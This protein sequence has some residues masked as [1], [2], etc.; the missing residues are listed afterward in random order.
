MN[1]I[2]PTNLSC[3]KLMWSCCSLNI[4]LNNMESSLC[5]K[6]SHHLKKF[7]G[8]NSWALVQ[9]NGPASQKW[10]ER[11]SGEKNVVHSHM[12]NIAISPQ[13]SSEAAQKEVHSLC[14]P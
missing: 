11:I 4:T 9:S 1:Y 7:N 3:T 14:H 13:S 6:A 8:I 5:Q 12:V 2:C 10:K